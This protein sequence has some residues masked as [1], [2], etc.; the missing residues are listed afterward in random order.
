MDYLITPRDKLADVLSSLEPGGRVFLGDGDYDGVITRVQPGTKEQRIS[1]LVLPGT[2]PVIHDVFRLSGCDYWDFIDLSVTQTQTV[3]RA[4]MVKLRGNFWKAKNLRLSHAHAQSAMQIGDGNHGWELI[5][6]EMSHT[7]ETTGPNQDHLLYIADA[8]DGKVIGF[9]GWDAPNGRG[10]KLGRGT[11]VGD[12]L[13]RRITIRRFAIADT[14]AGAIGLSYGASD[15]RMIDGKIVNPYRERDMD[16]THYPAVYGYRLRGTGNRM[17]RVIVK[18]TE[19]IASDGIE[20]V[21]SRF[22]EPLTETA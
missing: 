9:K 22:G 10:I 5:N 8:W 7:H 15:N 17:D 14:A 21:N 16:R 1:I 3:E 12:D 11:D 20:V 6:P 4:H 19:S 18:G 2:R 13:P